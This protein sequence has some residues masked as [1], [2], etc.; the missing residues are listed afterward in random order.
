MGKIKNFDDLEYEIRKIVY[1]ARVEETINGYLVT[2]DYG[3]PEEQI[4][5][6]KIK[7]KCDFQ[8]TITSILLIHPFGTQ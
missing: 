7:F 6:L 2:W 4:N 5:Q 3:T 1:S 8:P